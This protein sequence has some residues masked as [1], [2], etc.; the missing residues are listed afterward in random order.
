MG[1]KTMAAASV[2]AL[3]LALT[4]CGAGS[5]VEGAYVGVMQP[6]DED[7][8]RGI[9]IEIEQR[10]DGTLRALWSTAGEDRQLRLTGEE[11]ADGQFSLTAEPGPGGGYETAIDGEVEGSTLEAEFYSSALQAPLTA[12]R[13]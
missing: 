12:E 1:T 3:A 8:E 13:Q 4:G 5:S 2:L 10:N 6:P 9:S 7:A 11:P